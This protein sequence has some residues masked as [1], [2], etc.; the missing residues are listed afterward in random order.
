MQDLKLNFDESE[1]KID[2]ERE[3]VHD[4]KKSSK[5]INSMQK[6]PLLADSLHENAIATNKS[7]NNNFDDIFKT[8]NDPEFDMN[9]GIQS[10]SITLRINSGYHEDKMLGVTSLKIYD[11]KG[12]E[13][14]L[15]GSNLSLRGL[16]RQQLDK[17]FDDN[18]Y[19]TDKDKMTLLEFPI[20][21][22]YLDLE[23]KYEGKLPGSIRIWN[24][25]ADPNKGFKECNLLLDGFKI[26]DFTLNK[27]PGDITDFYN[28]D[29]I[30]SDNPVIPN[31]PFP[32][33]RETKE[34]QDRSVEQIRAP[35]RRSNTLKIS[36]KMVQEDNNQ[37]R[38]SQV[39]E[40]DN[41]DHQNTTAVNNTI[42]ANR[43]NHSK[44]KLEEPLEIEDEN[45]M[46]LN[47]SLITEG[48]D[49]GLDNIRGFKDLFKN[50]DFSSGLHKKK[51]EGQ[52]I[53]V[54]RRQRPGSKNASNV[55]I[56]Y[57]SG[58]RKNSNKNTPSKEN[59][60]KQLPPTTL[61]QPNKD[62]FGDSFFKTSD[63]QIGPLSPKREINNQQNTK[64]V[65]R[66]NNH[67]NQKQ[68]QQPLP[69]ENL[70]NKDKD[71]SY[72]TKGMPGSINNTSLEFEKI[73]SM[74]GGGPLLM[75]LN[76]PVKMNT[77]SHRKT[78]DIGGFG[79]EYQLEMRD[80][81]TDILDVQLNSTLKNLQKFNKTNLSRM[82]SS[83]DDFFTPNATL[84]RLDSNPPLGGM[85][86]TTTNLAHMDKRDLTWDE[87][88]A[89]SR[90]FVMPEMPM[91]KL[92]EMRIYSTW[93]DNFYVGLAGLE[94]FD[95]DGKPIHISASSVTAE[96][97]D[98]NALPDY[99]GDPRTVDKL[100]D[101]NYKTCD[102]IHSWLAP[103]YQN[104]VNKVSLGLSGLAS[105]SMIRLWNYN[106]SRIHSE[107]G[108]KNISLFLDGKL[109][110]FGEISQAPGSMEGAESTA[111]CLLFSDPSIYTMIEKHDWVGK[112]PSSFGN[113]NADLLKSNIERPNTSNKRSTITPNP[114]VVD[115]KKQIELNKKILEDLEKDQKKKDEQEN[116][117]KKHTDFITC[118]KMAFKVEETWGDEHYSGLTGIAFY[119]PED[120][121]IEVSPQVGINA[122]PRDLKSEG[123]YHDVRVLE[124]LVNGVNV[125]TD[126]G[127]MWLV[128]FK[129]GGQG[130]SLFINF[131]REVK[132]SKMKVWNYNKNERDTSRGIKRLKVTADITE[133]SPPQGLFLRK[134][135]GTAFLDFGQW[136]C[137]PLAQRER[138][139]K[140]K[141][142][143]QPKME[144][145][146]IPPVLPCGHHLSI[147]LL[148]TWG[149]SFYIGL[150]GIAVYDGKGRSLMKAAALA[151]DPSN[152]AACGSQMDVRKVENLTDGVNLGSEDSNVWL[153]PFINPRTQGDCNLGR[154]K[155]RLFVDFCSPVTISA[156][157]FWN[158]SKTPRR[159]VKEIEVYLDGA[160]IWSG[161]IIKASTSSYTNDCCLY[162]T[163]NS[164]TLDR[165]GSQPFTLSEGQPIAYSNEGTSS[166]EDRRE[167]FEYGALRRPETGLGRR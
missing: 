153:A 11:T 41:K 116:E 161:L 118:R 104:K 147:N 133:I 140:K 26:R 55:Q 78:G 137:F 29:F 117:Q 16:S 28:Q 152:L 120:Q 72:K 50:T 110:F 145:F 23:I 64:F 159:G 24:Y 92:L 139:L 101:G 98:L 30:I 87:L 36:Q 81:P 15:N 102:E 156:I 165:V 32:P 42:K 62:I 166:G 58:S 31:C 73:L 150:N 77:N 59:P 162:F 123:N 93:G 125:T 47:D 100:V 105:I 143:R 65:S 83:N 122:S 3:I 146:S 79:N 138:L 34:K 5:L 89:N 6:N 68:Q 84:Q 4:Y 63:L 27:A 43:R 17:V 69:H 86:N 61:A 37:S 8:N 157:R 108:A 74:G 82:L 99:N 97:A 154:S 1:F 129:K 10:H 54:S 155:N 135:P 144:Q 52:R 25:N 94:V 113:R 109:I 60:R 95:F 53:V 49:T 39:I 151:A 51:Q 167:V 66:R 90:D 85:I 48:G 35:S 19:T 132:L 56:N 126:E 46:M 67:K 33:K 20:L 7:L 18:V 127:S 9:S 14:V 114:E 45:L 119:D 13:I 57:R 88:I 148:S 121:I 131:G 70:N 107:R 76:Q 21:A 160:I 2:T 141:M 106:K 149:D 91:G 111:E 112:D 115:V 130:A 142:G 38:E 71:P 164:L 44:K 134:A 103:F 40:S 80:N 124:N 96:P 158:Y 22:D 75:D 12:K 136:I 163:G 128:S